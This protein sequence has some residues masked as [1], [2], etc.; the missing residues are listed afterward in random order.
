M[1]DYKNK[2]GS[3]ADKLKKDAPGTPIQQIQPIKVEMLKE[4]EVQFN[5]WIPKTLLKKIKAYGVEHDMTLKEINIRAL[6]EFIISS[7]S[8]NK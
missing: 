5:N 2:L 3:L 7:I 6:K 8:E 4:Q 1:E